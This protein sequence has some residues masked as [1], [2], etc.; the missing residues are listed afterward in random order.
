M[1]KMELAA[2]DVYEYFRLGLTTGM[3][4]KVSVIDWAD[5][6]IVGA[7]V[8]EPGLIELSLVG[9]GTYSQVIYVLSRLRGDRD[10]QLGLGL[11]LARADLL[12]EQDPARADDILA[13]LRLLLEEERLP[14][15]VRSRLTE[16]MDARASLQLKGHG[17]E[18]LLERL[19][20]FLGLYA[21]YRPLLEQIAG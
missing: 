1:P 14:A 20:S 18:T 7:A 9:S 15:D 12:L 2:R 6:H 4:D 13:G 10:S 5:R 11:L 3:V 19:T 8:P 21:R 17:S 16:I